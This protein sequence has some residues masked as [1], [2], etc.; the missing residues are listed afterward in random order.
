[1]RAETDRR[2]GGLADRVLRQ[3]PEIPGTAACP[4]DQP[5]AP[6]LRLRQKIDACA[7]AFRRIAGMPDY[8]AYLGHLRCHHPDRPIPSEREYFA[9]YVE[10]RYGNGPS[11]CC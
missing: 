9:L 8:D 5:S 4:A 2:T 11:R 3:Q 6:W 10:S 1:M 7:T